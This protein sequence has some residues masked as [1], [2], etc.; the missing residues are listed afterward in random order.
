M[1]IRGKNSPT[2]TPSQDMGSYVIVINAEKVQVTGRKA[3]QKTYFRH[4]QGRPGG[5]RVE[6]FDQ[7]QQVTPSPLM[8]SPV[9]RTRESLL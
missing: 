9:G 1:Y 5:W 2:Y 7:L 4:T 6:T 3:T 8:D